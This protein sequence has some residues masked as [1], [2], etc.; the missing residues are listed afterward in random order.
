VEQDNNKRSLRSISIRH[1]TAKKNGKRE[2]K[3]NKRRIII[4]SF[5]FRREFL[6]GFARS[7]KYVAFA[8]PEKSGL[9]GVERRGMMIFLFVE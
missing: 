1:S 2:K 7:F 8:C 6:C 5:R 9:W 4:K 3:K